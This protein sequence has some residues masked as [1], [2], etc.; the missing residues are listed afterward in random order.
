MRAPSQNEQLLTHL[1]QA[2]ITAQEA[3]T[4]HIG[5]LAAR[6]YDLRCKG[7]VILTLMVTLKKQYSGRTTRFA[8]YVLL[9][10]KRDTHA[11]SK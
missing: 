9:H 2:P 7:Y 11:V 4:Y 1:K 8:R 10:H 3:L 6:I 5:R